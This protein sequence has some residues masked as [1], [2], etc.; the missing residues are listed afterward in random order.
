MRLRRFKVT[1]EAVTHLCNSRK[2]HLLSSYWMVFSGPFMN[3][4]LLLKL[5]CGPLLL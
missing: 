4:K 5:R 1:A 2:F 3:K